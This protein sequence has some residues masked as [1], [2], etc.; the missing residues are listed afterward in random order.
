MI[1][2]LRWIAGLG[3]A[4]GVV[5]LAIAVMI[6]GY[7]IR[8][9][10]DRA[11]FGRHAACG[12]DKGSASA[13]SERRLA[14]SGGDRIEIAVPSRIVLRMGDGNDIVVRGAP[15][16]IS[17]VDVRGNRLTLDCRWGT[18]SRDVEVVLPGKVFRHIGLSG[19]TRL[20][21]EGLNQPEL[22][23]R[24]SGSGSVQAKGSVDRLSLKVS[25]SGDGRFADLAIKSLDLK[26]SGSGDVEAGP[27]EEADVSISGSGTLRLLSRP[28]KLKTHI[29]GSGRV[30]QAEKL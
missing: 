27:T 28:A 25:G 26:I 11:D 14:W 10:W 21:M 8:D 16:V 18:S 4:V 9:L 2:S 15:G 1:R 22:D 3:L 13:A 7:S 20:V 5:S 29:A 19:S 30:L 6:G 23:L 12:D 17:H 24:I